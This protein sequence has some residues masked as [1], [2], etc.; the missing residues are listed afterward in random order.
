M[1]AAIHFQSLDALTCCAEVSTGGD[2]ATPLHSHEALGACL[3]AGVYANMFGLGCVVVRASVA[4]ETGAGICHVLSRQGLWAFVADLVLS[5]K[6]CDA[7]P[8]LLVRVKAALATMTFGSPNYAVHAE[9]LQ[10]YARDRPEWIGRLLTNA[11]GSEINVVK[12]SAE[13]RRVTADFRKVIAELQEAKKRLK[14]AEA[15][16][17]IHRIISKVGRETARVFRQIQGLGGRFRK[18]KP[19]TVTHK[20]NGK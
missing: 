7:H 5:G 14:A 11:V 8:E 4:P 20:E 3:E 1:V 12:V 2:A 6:R 18:P 15:T 9:V 10:R 19:G 13:L 16:P 17:S